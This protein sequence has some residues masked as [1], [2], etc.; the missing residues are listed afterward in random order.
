MTTAIIAPP[1]RKPPEKWR[2]SRPRWP[3]SRLPA[4]FSRR[5]L[6]AL[7]PRYWPPR[8]QP[9]NWLTTTD[10]ITPWPRRA[11]FPHRSAITPPPIIAGR[12]PSRRRPKRTKPW[13]NV[14]WR[15]WMLASSGTQ[16]LSLVPAHG[17]WIDA[18][19]KEN[20]LAHM[21]AGQPVTIVADVLPNH[22][23][24]G[25]VA[26]LAPATGSRFS[27]LP[28]ENATGNFTKIVQRVPVRIA[29][30]GDGAK[31]DVLRPGLSVIVTVNEKS[32]R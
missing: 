4:S 11:R 27:I 26:S 29:L 21:R 1:S 6:P 13:P 8:R 25:H 2:R 5:P 24:K 30:E 31:L 28:A 19:F 18:N 15:C 32:P 10:A 20:Q 16:L 3:I 7:R 17:L 9:K 14:S 23:F 22:T 12:T